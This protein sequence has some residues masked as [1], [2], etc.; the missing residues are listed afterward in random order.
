[1]QDGVNPP[2]RWSLSMT[3]DDAFLEAIIESPDDDGLRLIYADWLEEH[4]QPERAEFIRVQIT[5][6]TLPAD[7]PRRQELKTRETDLLTRHQA[8]WRGRAPSGIVH[9]VFW[10]GFVEA[11]RVHGQTF[12]ADAEALFSL[13]PIRQVSFVEVEGHLTCIAFSSYLPRL[14][15]VDLRHHRLGNSW[16]A[17]L[18]RSPNLAR[19]VRLDLGGNAIGDWGARALAASPHLGG[20][21]TLGLE[22][23]WIEEDGLWALA[24]TRHL[25]RLTALYLA[26]NPID[27][28]GPGARALEERFGDR[29]HFLRGN[30]PALGW[31]R[32]EGAGEVHAERCPMVEIASHTQQ[33]GMFAIR[34]HG[35]PWNSKQVW[36][37]NPQARR[38][39]VSGP[40]HGDH[41]V[42]ITYLY[43][44]HGDRYEFVYTEVTPLSAWK[45][46]LPTQSRG[47]DTGS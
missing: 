26:G 4:G 5:L 43:E 23:N 42:W 28:S 41:S 19:L 34:L 36:V 22:D 16:V 20:L 7:N 8:E 17:V 10:R 46:G 12:V 11:V 30:A 25:G 45:I 39:Q 37:R 38:V 9:R 29:V 44:W 3:H 6:A 15:A 40:R 18:V 14:E 27:R 1:M 13:G 35:G 33:E 47:V 24:N 2:A 31:G 21:R 32:M